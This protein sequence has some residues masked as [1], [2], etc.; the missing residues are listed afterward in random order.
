MLSE[1]RLRLSAHAP[2][3]RA[4]AI[5]AVAAWGFAAVLVLMI[6]L[7][8]SIPGGSE[9]FPVDRN[10]VPIEPA[11][12]RL[13][14]I[15]AFLG[16]TAAAAA[17]TSAAHTPG[18]RF[19]KPTRLLVGLVGAAFAGETIEAGKA[20]VTYHDQGAA[21]ANLHFIPGWLGVAIQVAGWVGLA[22]A[23]L[24]TVAPGPV[25]RRP[26]VAAALAALPF[27]LA[28]L[29]Y[30]AAIVFPG[31]PPPGLFDASAPAVVN[32][33]G[34]LTGVSFFV[35][36]LLMWQS[37]VGAR[38]ARDVGS[39][40]ER[41]HQRI[42]IVLEAFVVAKLVWLALGYLDVLPAALG[43]EL[44]GLRASAGDDLL[45][46]LMAA[47]LALVGG[48]WL[49]RRCDLSFRD[50]ELDRAAGWLIAVFLLA[51]L[52]GALVLFV[53]GALGF[54]PDSSIRSWF[55]DAGGWFSERQLVCQV[56]AV[57]LAGLAGGYLLWRR[58]L[59]PV[60]SFLI[61]FSLLA[62]PRAIALT[63][64]WGDRLGAGSYQLTTLDAAV[65]VMVAVLVF[66]PIP[67]R[68]VSDAG[69]LV[70]LAASTTVAYSGSILS[71]IWSSGAF[72][73]ALV[74]PALYGFT[75]GARDLNEPGDH[76][77]VRVLVEAGAAAG[78][79][80]IAIML[81]ATGHAGPSAPTEGSVGRILILPPLAVMLTAAAC[82]RA[83]RRAGVAGNG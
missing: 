51:L 46:W 56:G 72:Y 35:A 6:G 60:A 66:A 19:G 25:G 53:V 67:R 59:I 74:L 64:S 9:T 16:V 79:I 54:A 30:L 81:V 62:L 10:G 55:V 32:V 61:L 21:L 78:L 23:L 76:H 4:Y 39:Q 17:L 48:W 63:A 27:C 43:G 1:R 71:S 44:G 24:A 57:Y 26:N 5:A 82:S 83:T 31:S 40:F 12:P 11:I 22:S 58:R 73:I 68:R 41:L 75:L 34:L 47:A 36:A 3:V 65:T 15:A 50:A 69:L 42:P 8:I 20:V 28:L 14:L 33:I 45:S 2:G 29:S 13:V 70:V 52:L 37:V 38:A 18:W 7:K 80:A 49:A 77:S